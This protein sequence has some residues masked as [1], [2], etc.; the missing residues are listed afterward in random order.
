MTT[1]KDKIE[2]LRNALHRHNH[3]YYV[4]N[5][6]E[7]SDREFDEM[8]HELQRLEEEHPEFND[9]N[10]PSIRV[11]SDILLFFDLRKPI[12][13]NSSNWSTSVSTY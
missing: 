13:L 10:S 3:N 9:E 7:I 4:L 8:M 12:F 5:Q 11:G 1:V 2:E 6:P